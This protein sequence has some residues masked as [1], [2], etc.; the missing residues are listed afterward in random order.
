MGHRVVVATR[1]VEEV[2]EVVLDRTLEVTITDPPAELDRRKAVA[3]ARLDIAGS[4]FGQCQPGQGR[5]PCRRILVRSRHR[6]PRGDQRGLGITR[7]ERNETERPMGR[8]DRS[9][10]GGAERSVESALGGGEGRRQVVAEPED[11]ASV[12]FDPRQERLVDRPV[13]CGVEVPRSSDKISAA[14]MRGSDGTFDPGKSRVVRG[15]RGGLEG[16]DRAGVVAQSC[17][18][19]A[20][21]RVKAGDI[22]MS[23]RE[24]RLVVFDRLAVGEDILGA[25]TG[26]PEGLRGLSRSA[27]VTLVRRDERQS[28]QVVA[29]TPSDVAP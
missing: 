16:L 10:V 5:D 3:Q 12:D 9:S 20:D 21:R 22:G 25:R 15:R 17:T 18:Q 1:C 6:L 29:A 11:H 27:S 2:G 26:K 7:R 24:R 8:T 23:Q 13:K 14:Q 28:S 19:S 4:S